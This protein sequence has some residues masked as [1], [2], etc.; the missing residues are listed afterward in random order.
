MGKGR[1]AERGKEGKGRERERE[2]ERESYKERGLDGREDRHT[3]KGNGGDE[4]RK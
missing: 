2:R 4:P 1:V 3:S